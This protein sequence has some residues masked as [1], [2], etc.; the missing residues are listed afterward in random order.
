MS[1]ET[2]EHAH[3]IAEGIGDDTAGSDAEQCVLGSLMA[4]INLSH[5]STCVCDLLPDLGAI[6]ILMDCLSECALQ[7]SNL[8]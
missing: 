4:L 6:S 7:L 1:L 3:E 2:K 5:Q 8:F